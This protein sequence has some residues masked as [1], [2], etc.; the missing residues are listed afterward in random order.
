MFEKGIFNGASTGLRRG[1]VATPTVCTEIRA[2]DQ[3]VCNSALH[4]IAIA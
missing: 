3:M 4:Q 2:S 1:S